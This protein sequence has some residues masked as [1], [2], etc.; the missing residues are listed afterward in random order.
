MSFIVRTMTLGDLA[1]IERIQSEAYSGYFLESADVIAQRFMLSPATAWVAEHEGQV[2]AYLVGYWSRVGKV[3]PLNAPFSVV[4]HADC[5]YL[6]DLA[7]L[8]SAQGYGLAKKLISAANEFALNNS[9]RAMALLSV[10]NSKE[11]WQGFGFSEFLD[12]ENKQKQNLE[13]YLNESDIAFYMV[14]HF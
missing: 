5:L 1:A 4:K 10:Q 3:N 11:F 12:L 13:T 8:K 6:H 9:A 2:C 14:K 7:L